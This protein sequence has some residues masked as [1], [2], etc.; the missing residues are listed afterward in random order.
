MDLYVLIISGLFKG[1]ECVVVCDIRLLDFN[2]GEERPPVPVGQVEIQLDHAFDK[3][4]PNCVQITENLTG[5]HFVSLRV[6]GGDEYFANHL[7]V[8][9]SECAKSTIE[10]VLYIY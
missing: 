3:P 5:S 8:N 10:V 6:L 4:R 7:R 2:D 9:K 1:N